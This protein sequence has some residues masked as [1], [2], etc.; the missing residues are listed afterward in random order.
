[1]NEI[2][3]RLADIDLN[4]KPMH[5]PNEQAV[6]LGSLRR[7]RVCWD[8]RGR[9]MKVRNVSVGSVTVTRAGSPRIIDDRS[10]TPRERITIAPSSVVYLKNPLKTRRKIM[11]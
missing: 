11:H 3:R 1:M 10:F 2:T 4:E 8:W 6:Y 9:K 5:D 7:N